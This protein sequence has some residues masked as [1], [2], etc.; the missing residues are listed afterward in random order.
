M[1]FD[2]GFADECGSEERPER[3]Q[4]MSTGDPSQVKQGVGDLETK[5]GKRS[6]I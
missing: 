5:P 6:L 1:H 2:D 4:E 3:N